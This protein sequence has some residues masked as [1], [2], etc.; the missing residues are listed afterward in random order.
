MEQQLHA[1]GYE[2][3]ICNI[4][5]GR[6]MS[7]SSSASCPSLGG[8]DCGGPRAISH[9]WLPFSELPRTSLSLG[10]SSQRMSPPPPSSD[11]QESSSPPRVSCGPAAA[12]GVLR[13]RPGISSRFSSAFSRPSPSLASS[14]V[15]SASPGS[16]AL[17]FSHDK[18][19][20]TNLVI[21]VYSAVV[22]VLIVSNVTFML[23]KISNR[24]D[25]DCSSR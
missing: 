7:I 20:S 13:R 5:F 9:G 2:H 11:F 16:P 17:T 14:S 15:D 4:F 21:I 3:I 1:A 22:L 10:I 25:G 12:S 19:Q 18:R 24:G 6:A 8:R 23:G